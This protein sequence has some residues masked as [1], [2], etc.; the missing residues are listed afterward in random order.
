MF[1][2]QEMAVQFLYHSLEDVI[3]IL[4]GLA[5]LKKESNMGKICFFWKESQFEQ[6]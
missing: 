5:D 4:M 3:K 2:N 6:H 1:P